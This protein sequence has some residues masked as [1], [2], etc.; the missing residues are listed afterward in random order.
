VVD[1]L[2]TTLGTY[3]AGQ[4][5]GA[6]YINGPAGLGANGY[7]LVDNDPR[8][9]PGPELRLDRQRA[10]VVPVPQAADRRPDRH[11]ARR[12]DLERTKGALWSYGTHKDTEL[13]AACSNR[14]N[15][16]SCVGNEK[17]F[18]T[19]VGSTGPCG[20]GRQHAGGHW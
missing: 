18:G 15:P 16:A 17:T 12:A 10:V 6:L 7:P 1:T 8:I 2:G 11:P 19:G 20:S 14:N 9:V 13:R 4:P 3:C 5:K